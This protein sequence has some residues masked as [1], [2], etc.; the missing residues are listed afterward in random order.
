MDHPIRI[1]PTQVWAW[2]GVIISVGINIALL[3]VF[4]EQLRAPEKPLDPPPSC[5]VKG[6][7]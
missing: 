2:L 6:V 7:K 5:V 4:I 1:T 3:W